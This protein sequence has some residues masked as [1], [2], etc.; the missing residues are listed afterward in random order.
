MDLTPWQWQELERMRSLMESL[1]PPR[2]GT[3]WADWDRPPVQVRHDGDD[4]VVQAPL[5]GMDP[6]DLDVRISEQGLTIRSEQQVETSGANHA[7]SSYS[8]VYR[9]VTFPVPIDA[10]R[11]RATFTHGLLEVRAPKRTATESGA[12]HRLTIDTR[13]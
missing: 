1:L 13:D 6:K 7:H 4:L 9:A 8:S 12:G 11:A 5:A 2:G 3:P 10:G